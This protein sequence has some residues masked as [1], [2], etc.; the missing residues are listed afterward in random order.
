M[1]GTNT[2]KNAED[3]LHKDRRLDEAAIQQVRHIVEVANIIALELE[4][5]TVRLS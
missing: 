1:I 3:R 2:P 4:F 5:R